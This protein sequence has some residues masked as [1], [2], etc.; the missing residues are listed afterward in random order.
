VCAYEREGGMGRAGVPPRRAFHREAARGAPGTPCLGENELRICRLG[1]EKPGWES[2]MAFPD[3]GGR[4]ARGP[5]RNCGVRGGRALVGTVI[6]SA[7]TLSQG[8]KALESGFV[9]VHLGSSGGALPKKA[10]LW[11][12]QDSESVLRLASN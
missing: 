1:G 4:R 8:E 5:G 9:L 7:M 11:Q 2:A 10:V 12:D 3:R 6:I